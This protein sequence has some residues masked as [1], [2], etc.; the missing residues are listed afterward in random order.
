MSLKIFT[1]AY[2]GNP[3]D[4]IAINP[5]HVITVFEGMIT[6]PDT[7]EI[8][9]ITNIFAGQNGSWQV[10]EDYLTVIARLNERD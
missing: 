3:S 7:N 5:N 8:G 6:N 4:S 1:N 2:K 10:E 9:S